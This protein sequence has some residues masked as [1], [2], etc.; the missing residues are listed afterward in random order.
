MN[1]RWRSQFNKDYKLIIKQGKDIRKLNYV[2]E[3][4]AVPNPLQ[5]QYRDH[6]LKG[7]YAG[8][9]ECH[10]EPNWLLIY[11]YETLEDNE[12]QLLLVRTGSHSD[13]FE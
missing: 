1:V 11:G 8:Y 4:L 3:E 12:Q 9:K 10:I 13:L 2:I 5:E 7:D 6:Y